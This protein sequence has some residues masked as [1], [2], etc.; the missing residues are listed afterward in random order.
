MHRVM[1]VC[2]CAAITLLWCTVSPLHAQESHSGS[3]DIKEK[4]PRP[5]HAYRLDFSIV[6]LQDA[7]KI[8][9]RRYSI[10]VNSEERDQ[11]KIGTRVPVV[12]QAYPDKPEIAQFQY[13]DVGTDIN[14]RVEEKVEGVFLEV[15]ADF[16]SLA[17][18]NEQH[19]PQ[20]PIVRQI[21][22]SGNTLAEIG[23]PT[24]IGSADDPN[25]NRTFQLE[26]TV[27]KLK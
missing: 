21:R 23:K 2:F 14:C 9:T 12:S 16:S 17:D 3:A 7:R 1:R 27:T 19:S 24:I 6:E 25:S 26:A 13:L 20:A 4:A 8:N 11:I 18:T 5:L 22:M 10:D 15:H